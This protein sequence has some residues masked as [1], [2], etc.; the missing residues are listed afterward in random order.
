M[1]PKER[2]SS[3]PRNYFENASILTQAK[4]EGYNWFLPN[5]DEVVQTATW[6][7]LVTEYDPSRPIGETGWI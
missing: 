3:L 1:W 4:K 2:G 6:F 5:G 7:S